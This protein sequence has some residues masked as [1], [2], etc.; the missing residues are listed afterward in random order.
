MS[1]PYALYASKTD[2]S[3]LNL[4]NRLGEK[5]NVSDTSTMLN[6]YLRKA[7][8]QN[9]TLELFG[10]HSWEYP[11]GFSKEFVIIS[12]DNLP[13][14]VPSGKNLYT[15]NQIFRPIISG[16]PYWEGGQGGQSMVFKEGT[17]ITGFENS[18][19]SPT[20]NMAFGF[21]VNKTE[22]IIPVNFPLNSTTITYTV[23]VGK[24]LIIKSG[25]S[26]RIGN[27]GN[28]SPFGFAF[29]IFEGITINTLDANTLGFT[30]YLLDK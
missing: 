12:N 26:F 14:T 21:L 30:G 25:G 22:K 15:F 28:Q 24:I 23:P 8:I 29:P 20:Q 4:T 17:I 11:D 6:P 16:I 10:I 27:K 1:V 7:S 13:Y 19:P 18:V 5:V 2:T 3:S 9:S